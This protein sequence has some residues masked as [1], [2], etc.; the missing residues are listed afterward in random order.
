MVAV[1]IEYAASRHAQSI[2]ELEA[3]AFTINAEQLEEVKRSR[4]RDPG[5]R[6]VAVAEQGVAGFV[7]GSWFVCAEASN[8]SL[9]RRRLWINAV[10]V[11]TPFRRNGIGRRLMN[12]LFERAEAR[13]AH[14]YALMVQ[15][16]NLAAIEL[17]KSLGFKRSQLAQSAYGKGLHG[18]IMKR[19]VKQLDGP[20]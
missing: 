6:L 5:V 17:Y 16:E 4:A 14:G 11:G 1:V 15:V 13:G 9:V 12:A 10:A 18:L 7:V 3:H 8:P 20:G 2:A 19:R